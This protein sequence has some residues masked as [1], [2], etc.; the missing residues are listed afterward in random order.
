MPKER[1]EKQIFDLYY[2]DFIKGPIGM[3]KQIY[4]HFGLEYTKE[5]E[6]KMVV[7]G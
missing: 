3:I 6:D 4:E 2:D 5:F 7:R 1:Q